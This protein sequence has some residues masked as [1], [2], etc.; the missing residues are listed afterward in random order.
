MNKSGG[1]LI[2]SLS[3]L[4]MLPISAIGDTY[5]CRAP[6]GRISYV[7]Q[8]PMTPGIKCEQMFVKKPPI[9]QEEAQVPATSTGENAASAASDKATAATEAAPAV[10][11]TK[12]EKELEAKRKKADAEDAKKKAA[13]EAESKQ[14]DE[15]LKAEN[16]RNAQSNVATYKMGRVRRVD[17]NGEY[18]YLDDAAV[19]QGLAQAEKDVAANCK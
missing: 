8:L 4:A 17:A 14:T 1:L 6:D 10:Q 13:K 18:Y 19:A 12:A 15:K 7:N 16:C 9:S 3:G 5:K 2:L 11:K